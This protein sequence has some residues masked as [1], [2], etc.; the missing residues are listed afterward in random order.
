MRSEVELSAAIQRA[1]KDKNLGPEE[2]RRKLDVSEV[3]LQKIISGEVVPSHHLEK[4]M[5]EVLDI[6]PNRVKRLA[7]LRQRGTNSDDDKANPK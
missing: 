4:E 6:Q 2:L 7:R 5:V 1:M 3:M